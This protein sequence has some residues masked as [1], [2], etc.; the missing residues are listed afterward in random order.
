MGIAKSILKKFLDTGLYL[1]LCLLMYRNI[2]VAG[3]PYSPS[4][5]LQSRE[6]R[7][8]L[9][10]KENNLKPNVVQCYDDRK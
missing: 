10:V 9:I 2:P 3:L 8:T 4:Q 5:L 7:N 1:D 6:L